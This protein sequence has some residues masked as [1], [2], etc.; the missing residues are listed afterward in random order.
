MAGLSTTL[1]A[2]TGANGA[3]FRGSLLD[4]YPFH[5]E[6]SNAPTPADAAETLWGVCRNSLAHDLGFDVR[7]NAKTPETKYM[8]HLTRA[9]KGARGIS[10]QMI[11]AL[12]NHSKRPTT[13]ATVEIRSDATVLSI[14]ALYWGVRYMAEK[15]FSDPKRVHPAEAFLATL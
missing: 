12:E 9:A 4:Y 5:Q 11:A 10:E 3:R 14:D 13:K 7:K 2:Q 6:P 1:Y 8:R 15:M